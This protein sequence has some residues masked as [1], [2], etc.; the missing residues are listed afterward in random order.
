MRGWGY[1]YDISVYS[2][3]IGIIVASQDITVDRAICIYN[4]AANETPVFSFASELA[5][6]RQP[7]ESFIKISFGAFGFLA[8]S[9]N[10][11]YP[12]GSNFGGALG[13]P[14]TYTSSRV[15]NAKTNLPFYVVLPNS[16]VV[17]A[18]DIAAGGNHSVILA[19]SIKPSGNNFTIIRP[20]GYPIVTDLAV[21]PITEIAQ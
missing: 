21:Y 9:Q 11:F 13:Y 4:F 12:Y 5:S 2:N 17:G 1:A 15:E 7:S 10:L 19:S 18:Y 6:K 3:D 14:I 8:L 16:S 20:N